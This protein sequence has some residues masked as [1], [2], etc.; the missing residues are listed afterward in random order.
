M[1]LNYAEL[2]KKINEINKRLNQCVEKLEGIK[3]EEKE[4]YDNPHYRTWSGD[5]KDLESFVD[6]L[7]EWLNEP[8]VAEAKR[9]LSDLKKWAGEEISLDEIEKEWRFLS[10]NVDKIKKM[11]E[12]IEDI[13]YENIKKKTSSWVL[14]RITEKDIKRAETWSVNANRFSKGLI[15]LENKDVKSNLA[16]EVKKDA[17]NELL[18]IESFDK[19]KQSKIAEYKSLIEKAEGII[20]GKPEEIDE[21]VVIKTYKQKNK[22]IKEKLPIIS[23]IVD[24]I[25]K[26]LI[27]LEWVKEFSNF[28]EYREIYKEKQDAIKKETLENIS[29]ALDQVVEKANKW[30]SSKKEEIDKIF[31]RTERMAKNIDKEELKKRLDSL[32]EVAENISWE[33]PDVLILYEIISKI[34]TLRTEMRKELIQKLQN[35]DA[36]L[37]IE[38]PDIVKDLGKEKGWNFDRFLAAFGVLLRNGLIEIEKIRV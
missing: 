27:E 13:K 3:P 18:K 15:Q 17:I 6:R 23:R 9:C 35:E 34:K 4:K 21:E 5:I 38:E 2:H 30:K 1:S 25:K 19:D 7:E 14:K 36:I 29:K 24:E 37:I 8:L 28:E 11:H 10:D 20:E 16:K 31:S 33:K 26:K 22:V 12:L 32:K